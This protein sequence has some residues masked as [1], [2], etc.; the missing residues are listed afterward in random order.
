MRAPRLILAFAMSIAAIPC[1]AGAAAAQDAG[2]PAVQEQF[3]LGNAALSRSEWRGAIQHFDSAY[4]A[5]AFPERPELLL[6]LGI[7][8]AHAGNDVPAI[9]WLMA[10]LAAEPDERTRAGIRAEIARLDRVAQTKADRLRSATLEMVPALLRAHP[11]NDDTKTRL[12]GAVVASLSKAGD[13]DGAFRILDLMPESNVKLHAANAVLINAA[14]F[15]GRQERY[16]TMDSL[17]QRVPVEWFSGR[18]WFYYTLYPFEQE[19]ERLPFDST[20]RA[21]PWIPWSELYQSRTELARDY[22]LASFVS[23]VA[24]GALHHAS[25]DSAWAQ[26]APSCLWNG[27]ARG[28][29]IASRLRNTQLRE[30]TVSRLT[31]LSER[32]ASY[33]LAEGARYL[34]QHAV[35]LSGYWGLT[36][37]AARTD[38]AA[39][40]EDLGTADKLSHYAART[41]RELVRYRAMTLREP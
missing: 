17:L 32:C 39:R 15:A 10:A 37:L 2:E 21:R 33:P 18:N 8:H 23:D 7:A 5:S 12:L 14:W 22:L 34:A 36:D 41:T 4:R 24:P 29:T 28:A 38:S 31:L 27:P 30:L 25:M 40:Q 6:N 35:R 26:S 9:A 13:V 3:R 11:T 19:L 16:A 20:A 1:T